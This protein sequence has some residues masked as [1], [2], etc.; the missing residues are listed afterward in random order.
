MVLGIS[1]HTAGQK[2][3]A[4]QD[5]QP[6]SGRY[7]PAEVQEDYLL[8]LA[9]GQDYSGVSWPRWPCE[10]GH[11]EDG[12]WAVQEIC[13]K[14]GSHLSTY[15]SSRASTASSPGRMFGQDD[16]SIICCWNVTATL[17]LSPSSSRIINKLYSKYC[18]LLSPS[19]F[20]LESY[21]FI[22]HYIIS[23]FFHN[24][25]FLHA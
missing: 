16:Y 20:P 4:A 19:P 10:S 9:L 5:T 24:V 7:R 15:W 22:Q 8:P 18:E 25:H 23:Q 3:V 13:G 12:H 1:Q 6:T 2:Q 17:T 21:D 14:T 11:G